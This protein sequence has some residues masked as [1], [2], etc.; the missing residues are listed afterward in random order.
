[1]TQS[2]DDSDMIVAGKGSA[3]RPRRPLRS[4]VSSGHIV[5][6]V[7]GLL[8]LLLSLSV[9]RRVD[10]TVPV[11]VLKHDVVPGTRVVAT[12]FRSTRVHVDDQQLANLVSPVA[13]SRLSGSIV[14]SSMRAGDLLERSDVGSAASRKAARAVSF[15][16]DSSL[17]V[18]GQI[19]AG[20]RV[21]VLAT[22]TDGSRSGYV[23]VGVD[24]VGVSDSGSGPLRSAD[25][26]LTITVAVDAAGAQRL[27][28]AL[29]GADLLVVRSTGAA[30]VTSVHWFT[31]GATNG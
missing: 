22:A 12:M 5:M 11:V 23:L 13:L 15:P 28:S 20:D 1:M 4:R 7:A 8:G 9:L 16:V 25:G 30:P 6:V 26:Q 21:D 2:D 3:R 31:T 14:V 27:A 17:A 24:V 18:G 10:T 19:S 29:H